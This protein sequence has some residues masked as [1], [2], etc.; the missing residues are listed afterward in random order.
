MAYTEIGVRTGSGV[1]IVEVVVFPD[2]DDDP[3][4]SPRKERDRRSE[5]QNIGIQPWEG[6]HFVDMERPT[7]G[8]W[9]GGGGRGEGKE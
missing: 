7:L 3:E 6:I 4:G 2:G 8:T 9:E 5:E 1:D